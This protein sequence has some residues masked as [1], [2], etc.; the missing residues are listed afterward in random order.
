MRSLNGI[1]GWFWIERLELGGVHTALLCSPCYEVCTAHLL[2]GSSTIKVYQHSGELWDRSAVPKPFFSSSTD[3]E[4]NEIQW[5]YPSPCHTPW[6][7]GLSS[8][9]QPSRRE[10]R[11]HLTHWQPHLFCMEA[12]WRAERQLSV[13]NFYWNK[14]I[15]FLHIN[16]LFSWTL[17]VLHGWQLRVW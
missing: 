15:P 13:G 14:K 7:N 16:L 1:L 4:Q 3:Q 9:I 6:K 8:F 11:F 17:R 12:I 10:Q 2:S 5:P